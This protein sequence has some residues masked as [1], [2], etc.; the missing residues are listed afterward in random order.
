[1]KSIDKIKQWKPEGLLHGRTMTLFSSFIPI[2]KI[3]KCN[4]ETVLPEK[5]LMLSLFLFPILS[6]SVPHWLTSIFTTLAV[7]SLWFAWK[8]TVKL[9]KEEKIL[10]IAFGAYCA[11]IFIS[12]TFNGWTTASVH[13]LGTEVKYLAFIPLYLY[14]RQ[15][16]RSWKWLIAG[17]MLGAIVLGIHAIYDTYWNI[18]VQQADGVYG[19]II[20]GDLAVL[21]FGVAVI[22]LFMGKVKNI[23]ERMIYILAI[24]FSLI[25]IYFSC[26][27]NA[28]VAVLVI[29]VILP[30]ILKQR[31]STKYIVN[32]YITLAVG[33]IMLISIAPSRTLE[34]IVQAAEGVMIYVTEDNISSEQLRK[35][36]SVLFRVELFRAANMIFLDYPIFGIGPGNAQK[37]INR[38]ALDNKIHRGFYSNELK[39]SVNVHNAYSESLASQGILG[40]I[41]LLTVLLYPLYFFWSNRNIRCVAAYFGIIHMVGFVIFSLTEIPFIHNNFTAIFLIY[42][43]AFFSMVVKEKYKE[44]YDGD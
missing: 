29:F 6:L 42:L 3:K 14:I 9:S 18:R 24:L 8:G 32:S 38:F 44:Q 1:M 31:Y 17:S 40:F 2:D 7:L 43:A 5:F 12:S 39:V 33:V 25:A 13:R 16:P 21:L 27:M 15:Y 28:I 22:R 11:S 10:L 36:H 37:Y 26:S 35:N 19:H 20:F 30:L 34:G 41:A 4:A 23:Y